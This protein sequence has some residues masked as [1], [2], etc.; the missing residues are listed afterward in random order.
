MPE[1]HLFSSAL[2]YP[3]F[4]VGVVLILVSFSLILRA[5]EQRDWKRA[6]AAGL[7]NG[8]LVLVY[9]FLIILMVAIVGAFWLALVY[10]FGRVTWP[11]TGLLAI[12]LGSASP[13]RG[14]L[15]LD[16]SD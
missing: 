1:A 3:H 2:S 15:R 9:P 6:I 7:A 10:K 11:E 12:A 8:L 16:D 13:T 5:V 14:L 4:A